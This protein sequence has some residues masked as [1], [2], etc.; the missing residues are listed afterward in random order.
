MAPPAAGASTWAARRQPRPRGLSMVAGDQALG[1]DESRI[2]CR[3]LH[4]RAA[5]GDVSPAEP[6]RPPLLWPVSWEG[7]RAFSCPHPAPP[8]PTPGPI[9]HPTRPAPCQSCGVF[10][11]DSGLPERLSSCRSRPL[12]PAARRSPS[13]VLRVSPPPGAWGPRPGSS[14]LQRDFTTGTPG[15]PFPK[16]TSGPCSQ[17]PRPASPPTSSLASEFPLDPASFISLR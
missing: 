10:S 14:P 9:P 13:L 1:V 6:P 16:R 8:R 12:D 5:H 2:T 15:A 3:W 11:S 4:R 7:R 17:L